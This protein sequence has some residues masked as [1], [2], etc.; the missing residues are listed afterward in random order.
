[1]VIRFAIVII[2][3]GNYYDEDNDIAN[4]SHKQGIDDHYDRDKDNDGDGYCSHY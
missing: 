2:I 4:G 3:A 1:M